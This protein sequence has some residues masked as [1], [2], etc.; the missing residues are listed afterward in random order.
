[1]DA[2][3]SPITWT[4]TGAGA[5]TVLAMSFGLQLLR[6]LFPGFVGYLRDSQNVG[7]LELAPVA[8][9]LFALAFLAALLR[10]IA[11]MRA[12]LVIT[13]GGLGA[14]RLIEQFS[15]SPPLDLA[16][17]A[18]GVVL[19]LLFV[20]LAIGA[21]RP[22]GKEVGVCL[23]VAILLGVALDTAIH[24]GAATLDLSWQPGVLPILIV[25][26]LS[27]LLFLALRRAL[28][29]LSP[30]APLDGD[31]RS[32]WPLVFFGPWLFLQL[33]VY[34]NVARTAALTGLETPASGA[35][36]VAGN[37]LALALL[38]WLGRRGLPLL[39][40]VLITGVLWVASLIIPE[41]AG[42][43]A[44]LLLLAGQVLGVL[45]VVVILSAAVATPGKPGLARTTIASGSGHMLLV[46]LTF[47]YYVSYDISMGF[48]APAILPII[49]LLVALG[50]LLASRGRAR[51]DLHDLVYT[52]AGGAALLLVVPLGLLLTWDTPAPIQPAPANRSVRVMTY[53]LH[54]GF[55]TEGRLDLEALAR[56][57]EDSGADVVAL[58]EVSRGWLIW[59]GVDMLTWLSQRLDMPYVSGPTGDAQWGNAILSRYPLIDTRTF[60]LPPDDLLLLRG[61]I[62]AEIDLGGGRLTMIATHFYHRD[63]QT[64]I[65]EQQAAALLEALQP[66]TPTVILGDLN[67]RPDSPEMYMLAQAGLVDISA[68]LGE[69]PT[70]TYYAANPDHQIDYIWTTPDVDAAD[71]AIIQTT[72]SD[73]LPMVATLTVP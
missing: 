1:M 53:N 48:R 65:R 24:V 39:G 8:L 22:G 3:T 37:A 27:T 13:A 41:P 38:I 57:I 71:F 15:T 70:Y 6:T 67:A 43:L 33:L 29:D 11:G 9:G 14:L 2:E 50:A 62:Q 47:L 68:V 69:Q 66:G 26:L 42:L 58:Q 46:L 52:P 16:L 5:M 17:S 30:E 44:V 73:H 19:F 63:T 34:Q 59:G 45:M 40:I 4:W 25:A 32:N 12:A 61:Y 35:L 18:A 51:L 72:A 55:N 20:P 7:S 54:N 64:E 21:A 49:A 10:R 60:P 23:G 28:A 56:V 36:V 31:W